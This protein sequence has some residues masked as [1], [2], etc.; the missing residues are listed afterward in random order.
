MRKRAQKR[1]ELPRSVTNVE[2]F[3]LSIGQIVHVKCRDYEGLA[4]IVG[5]PPQGPGINV[6]T[7]DRR[8]LLVSGEDIQEATEPS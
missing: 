1:S 8:R 7:T 6:Y 3:G 4:R 5:E 2:Y